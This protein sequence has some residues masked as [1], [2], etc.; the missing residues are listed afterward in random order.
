MFG[1]GLK[2]FDAKAGI[3]N[4]ELWTDDHYYVFTTGYFGRLLEKGQN[5]GG[6]IGFDVQGRTVT[7]LWA[8]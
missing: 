5:C 8:N 2:F 1:C 3:Q 7:A 4:T 6:W